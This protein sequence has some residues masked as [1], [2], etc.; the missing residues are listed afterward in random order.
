M[1]PP[2]YR[3][4]LRDQ[5]TELLFRQTYYF[6]RVRRRQLLENKLCSSRP[7]RI[8]TNKTTDQAHLVV[9][10]GRE[11]TTLRQVYIV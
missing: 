3:D 1:S 10:A 7:K 2:P 5:T 8:Y 9:M 4:V 6:H 11:K